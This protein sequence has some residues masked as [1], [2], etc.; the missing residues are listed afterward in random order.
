MATLS[1]TTAMITKVSTQCPINP[2]TSAAAIS[3]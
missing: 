3:T 1:T 2:V